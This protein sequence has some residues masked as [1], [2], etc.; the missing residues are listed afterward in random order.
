MV[1]VTT[2]LV[3]VLISSFLTVRFCAV[4]AFKNIV[5]LLVII[6]VVTL[7]PTVNNTG[8]FFNYGIMAPYS[9]AMITSNHHT[10]LGS[11]P[12]AYETQ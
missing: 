4:S 9:L 2:V 6:L 10:R 11:L 12:A 1:Y 5:T 3:P 8:Y 7:A